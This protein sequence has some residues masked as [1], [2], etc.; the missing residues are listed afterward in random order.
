M[1]GPTLLNITVCRFKFPKFPL[2][3]TTV[4]KSC[5]K[6]EDEADLNSKKEDLSKI[7]KFLVRQTYTDKDLENLESWSSLRKMTFWDFLLEVGMFRTEKDI[8]DY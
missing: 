3:E 8:Y 7:V 5:S 1:H 2:N 4:V 6:D